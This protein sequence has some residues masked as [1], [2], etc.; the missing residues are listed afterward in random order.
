MERRRLSSGLAL[1]PEFVTS[2]QKL[3]QEDEQNEQVTY[4]LLTLCIELIL[5]RALPTGG[6]ARPPVWARLS[7]GC[8]VTPEIE[9]N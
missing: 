4:H 1:S 7:C 9:R 5:W 6:P 2:S 8:F 3:L